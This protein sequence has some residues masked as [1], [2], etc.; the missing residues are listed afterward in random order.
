[1]K[2]KKRPRRPSKGYSE[3]FKRK[4]CEEYLNTSCTKVYLLRKY[5]IKFRSAVQYW[6]R[7]LGY[8]NDK[9]IKLASKREQQSYS[10]K[11]KELHELA[12]ELEQAKL[13]AL[14][15][16]KMIEIAEQKFNLPIQKK[17]DTKQSKK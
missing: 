15:Y 6:L 3:V 9:R 13:E 8:L 14:A 10:W 5:N 12:L 17:S 16:R 2:G 7:E 11:Q 1:M 4:V